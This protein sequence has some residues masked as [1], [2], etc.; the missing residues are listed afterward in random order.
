MRVVVN[1]FQI[2]FHDTVASQLVLKALRIVKPHGLDVLGDFMDF[3][4]LSR[5]DKDPS[6]K[7]L[8]RDEVEVGRRMLGKLVRAAGRRC[9]DRRFSDGNHED[10]LRRF[11]W[12]RAPQLAGLEGLNVPD[13]L[14]LPLHGFRHYNYLTPYRIGQLWFHHGKVVRKDAGAT[15]R[16]HMRDVGASII[17]GHSH[18]MAHV[19]KTTW[20]GTVHGWE[21][22]CLCKLDPEYINGPPDWQQGFAIV[23]FGRGRTFG[24]EQVQI[25]RGHMWIGGKEYGL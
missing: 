20:S 17:V 14:Q 25:R 2:P 15:A 22:G 6:R 9:K 7:L 18:R 3:Y 8:L 21:N 10:R 13:L 23:R 1:D 16:A 4:K 11:L 19:C 12:S 5:F 24:V